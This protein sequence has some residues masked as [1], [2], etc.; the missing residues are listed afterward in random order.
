MSSSPACHPGLPALLP[1]PA[2]PLSASKRAVH[3]TRPAHSP[4]EF[5][6]RARRRRARVVSSCHGGMVERRRLML[7]PAIILTIGALQYSLEKG[8]AKA[9]FTDTYFVTK[10]SYPDYTET[11]SGLQY[12]LYLLHVYPGE[13]L[14]TEMWVD[15]QRVQYQTKVKERD[16]AV[17]SGYVLLKQHIP[18]SLFDIHD[19]NS[20]LF[21]YM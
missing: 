7:I 2:A 13:T 4:I 8:A 21:N 14:V 20:R 11:E 17:L 10:K 9:E 16:R 12:K 18:S 6:S 19:S 5:S 15:G 1:R 3:R